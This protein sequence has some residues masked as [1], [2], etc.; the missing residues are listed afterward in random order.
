LANKS[1]KKHPGGLS[2]R[3]AFPDDEKRLPW[4]SALLN[5]YAIADTGVAVAIRDVEKR[6]KKKLAC[7]RNCDVCCHQP[8][9]PLYPHELQGLQWFVAVKLDAPTRQIVLRRCREHR[10]GLPCPFLV[11]RACAVHPVRP[12]ACRQYNVF[13]T[14]CSPGEDPYYARRDDVLD[15]LPDYRD[16]AFAAA[17]SIYGLEKEKDIERAVRIVKEKIR[18]LQERDWKELFIL[19]DENAGAGK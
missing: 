6:Q 11:E 5:A 4:L 8:D 17:L 15:P 3:L 2:R 13:T 18:N 14:P 19:S 12:L 10:Q 9:I 16:R 1:E 7:S